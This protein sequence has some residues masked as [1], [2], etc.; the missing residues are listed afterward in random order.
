VF[1]TNP[2][3]SDEHAKRFKVALDNV[4]EKPVTHERNKQTLWPVGSAISENSY[5]ALVPLYPSALTHQIFQKINQLRYSEEN[6]LARDNR[7]KKTAEQQAYVSIP[8]M[9]VT[10]LGGTKPENVGYLSSKQRGR[11]FLLPSLAPVLASEK[12]LRLGK[13]QDSLFGPRLAGVCRFGLNQLYDV[14]NAR[15]N[16][17]SVRDERKEALDFILVAVFKQAEH[18]QSTNPP[19]WSKD[20]QLTMPEK[21]WLDPGR[22]ELEGEE[23]FQQARNSSD[24][25]QAICER[26]ALWVNARLQKK[27]PNQLIQ[28]GDAQ[29]T[30]WLRE[31][32]QAIKAS[33][34]AGR[35]VFA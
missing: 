16:V 32:E 18:I 35:E 19:G 26:F 14:V 33:Q 31:M 6:K 13:S 9:G 15:K 27:F 2:A 23:A 3:T 24:W 30:E 1:S 4:L 5:V 29:Y 34:R 10:H 21:Y 25:Q 20:Y 22:A 11:N 12:T 28:F 17:V 8:D 7:K